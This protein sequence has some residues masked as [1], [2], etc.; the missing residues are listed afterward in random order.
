MK[1]TWIKT[2]SLTLAASGLM[3]STALAQRPAE[4]KQEKRQER[5]ETLQQM[6]P[7]ERQKYFQERMQQRMQTM[8]PEQRAAFQERMQQRMQQ[9]QGGPGGGQQNPEDAQRRLLNSA[10]VT[11]KAT[12]DV[13]I[14]FAAERAAARQPVLT[15]ARELSAA[16]ADQTGTPEE[17]STRQAEIFGRLQA[18]AATYKTTHEA[19][20][21]ALD[22]KINYTTNPRLRS[23]LTLIGLLG[24][25]SELAGGF[26]AI[27]PNGVAGA[28]NPQVANNMPGAAGNNTGN[29]PGT[30]GAGPGAGVVSAGGTMEAPAGGPDATTPPDTTA[31]Q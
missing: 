22:A 14:A 6:T 7:E 24:N 8:T 13:I 3:I 12:Q 4:T 9:G 21:G 29:V 23:V 30:P 16:L 28:V 26:V 2:C 25:E 27:F 15:I 18:A 1:R 20:L 10:G 11:D 17:Q 5:R 31:T 19:A